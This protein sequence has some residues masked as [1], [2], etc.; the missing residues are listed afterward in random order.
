MDQREELWSAY[1]VVCP[2]CES[3]SQADDVSC[4]YCGADRH[5]AVLT[6]GHAS[7]EVDGSAAALVRAA[8]S[9]FPDK[10]IDTASP[11]LPASPA[12]PMLSRNRLYAALAVGLCVVLGAY[13]WLRT[14]SSE[15]AGVVNAELASAAGSVRKLAAPVVAT[16]HP[17]A[18]K[19]TGN[20]EHDGTIP[21]AQDQFVA[22]VNPISRAAFSTGGPAHGQPCSVTS[23]SAS[24]FDTRWCD[25]SS[26][27]SSSTQAAPLAEKPASLAAPVIVQTPDRVARDDVSVARRTEPVRPSAKAAH[28]PSKVQARTNKKEA[29]AKPEPKS[30]RRTTT[31]EKKQS[32]NRAP[33]RAAASTQKKAEAPHPDRTGT[34][35]AP[36]KPAMTAS[37]SWTPTPAPESYESRLSADNHGA[38]TRDDT[39]SSKERQAH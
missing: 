32:R 21:L 17:R 30:S 8:A 1:F 37:G 35:A 39:S 33:Q 28:P 11:A 22:L 29:R 16:A 3:V 34:I 31:A 18:P 19:T 26:P 9:R 12:T 14:S 15:N 25:T 38:A 24:V 6:R 20:V 13:G 7:L 4:P 2:R 10:P 23:G 5:G 27:S 36:I